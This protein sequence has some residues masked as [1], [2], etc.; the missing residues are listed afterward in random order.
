MIQQEQ[1]GYA[2]FHTLY[3]FDSLW[4]VYERLDAVLFAQIPQE[5]LQEAGF[6]ARCY[7][8]GFAFTEAVHS[9]YR[10]A[11]VEIGTVMG[12]HFCSFGMDQIAEQIA[13]VG[14]A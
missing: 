13:F 4:C 9:Q 2:V 10:H 7:I 3:R 5:A 1:V 14:P 11:L 12:Q 6:R 8:V